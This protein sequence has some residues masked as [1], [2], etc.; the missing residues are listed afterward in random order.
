MII[1]KNVSLKEYC[2][3]GTGGL[4]D[5]FTQPHHN[6]ELK[7]ALSWAQEKDV[8]YEVIGGGYNL[9]ISDDGYRGLIIN[10]SLLNNTLSDN[11]NS[12]LCGAG[13]TLTEL[14][15][16]AISKDLGGFEKLSGIPGTV[17]G[18]VKMNAGAFGV[19]IKDN[20]DYVLALN[21][22]SDE[23]KL[24][25]SEC[26]FGYRESVGLDGLIVTHVNFKFRNE[27]KKQLLQIKKEILVK[28]KE[29]QPLNKPS[30]GSVFK[31]PEGTFAGV[32]IEECGLK[33][34]C[35]G[36]AVVS[37]KHANFILNKGNATSRDIK[38]LIDTVIEVVLNKKGV[39]LM[40]EVKFIGFD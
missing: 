9:L 25:K 3:Y 30:C 20:I 34:L 14:I 5:F 35:E 7:E 40:P 10:T 19:E 6:D 12:V 27:N 24:T 22:N 32:L 31:R 8:K 38:Y 17:G 29:K 37:E 4:A 33:G 23:I 18:G 11:G 16:F 2:N 1:K 13:V 15:N 36:G 26:C 39:K 21:S 28:R